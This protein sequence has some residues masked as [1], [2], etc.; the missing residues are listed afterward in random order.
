M[1]TAIEKGLKRS[2]GSFVANGGGRKSVG[3]YHFKSI[4]L[5]ELEQRCWDDESPIILFINLIQR[6]EKCLASGILKHYF[7]AECNLLECVGKEELSVAGSAA[8]SILED[9]LPAV[10]EAPK[11]PAVVYGEED[12]GKKLLMC[13]KSLLAGCDGELIMDTGGEFELKKE[14]LR[15]ILETIDQ[16]RASR[17][18]SMQ[19]SRNP[20]RGE[21]P[22]TLTTLPGELFPPWELRAYN[23]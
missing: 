17:W 19:N 1:K 6:L 13:L 21:G 3:S 15:R 23:A 8:K 2:G 4:L 7:F 14:N 12:E 10:F 20:S 5:W 18:E 9:P 11:F 16:V 22:V